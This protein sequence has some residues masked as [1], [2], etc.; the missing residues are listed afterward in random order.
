MIEVWGRKIYNVYSCCSEGTG[1]TSKETDN[2]YTLSGSS[3]EEK[4]W[5]YLTQYRKLSKIAAAGV[6]ANIKVE[7]G[8]DPFKGEVGGGGGWGL[9]Q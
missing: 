2:T 1:K 8:F 4:I 7:S 5:N 9:I 3:N 6:M